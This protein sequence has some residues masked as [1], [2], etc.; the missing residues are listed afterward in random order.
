MI[1]RKRARLAA[2]AALILAA[3]VALALDRVR[4]ESGANQLENE[5]GTTGAGVVIAIIDRGIDW[6]HPDFINDDGT[7]RIKW[8]LDMSNQSN[9]CQVGNPAPVEY[10]EA[11]INAALTGGPTVNS[12]DAVGH[13]TVSAGIA[14]SNGR[15]FANAK[16]RGIA[17]EADLVIVKLTSEGA[18]AH[19][20]EPAETG[21]IACF[22][23]ALDWLETKM[24]AMGQPVV[25][26][27]NIGTQ[28]GPMDG[29]SALSQ[30]I[31]AVFGE[32]NP[33]RIWISPV[34]D[35]GDFDNHAGGNFDNTQDTI[36]NYNLLT[37]GTY[38]ET[39]WYDGAQP[40]E[41]S[42]ELP[43]GTIVGPV[44][45]G[46]SINQSGVFILHYNPGTEF[47]PWA[48]TSGDYA[49]WIR[50]I[51]GPGSGSIRIRGQNAGVG[52][53]DM[54]GS[55]TR[56]FVFT[57]NL[58]PGRMSDIATT[59]SGIV[60]G[61]YVNKNSYTDINSVFRNVSGQGSQDEKWHG[62][63]GGPTRDNRSPGVDILSPGHNLIGSY[64]PTSYWGSLPHLLI[65]DGGGYY[66]IQGAAS[67][68]A[69]IVLGAVALLLEIDPT[70]TAREAR[71]IL[72]STAKSDSFTG[73]TPNTDWG[74]G[75]LD[76][77]AAGMIVLAQSQLSAIVA[78]QDISG[79]G[80]P[81]VGVS[82]PGSTHVHI[83]DG[84]T[85]AL[86]TDINFGD[87]DAL[88]MAVVPDLNASGNPEIAM[89]NEQA[90]GQVRVQIRDTLTGAITKNLYYGLAYEPVAM[91]VIDDY[92]GNG[93]PEIA[94]LGSAAGTDAVRVQVQDTSTGFPRQRVPRHT[95]YCA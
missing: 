52:R 44:A 33:G 60:V 95:E 85:D 68:A 76:I 62:S 42:V 46:G 2:L 86:I 27:A 17:P 8:L 29:T 4:N 93:L 72:R 13:G 35:E 90:S 23:E 55:F 89:L 51:A 58:V 47:Y 21:F 50:I 16:Y 59:R 45:P 11:D 20:G 53:F 94:V 78:M 49:V 61:A 31:D 65:D 12:R 39:M 83:R 48:S 91:D 80:M 19:D 54:Y 18:P 87:D 69:P 5:L 9:W 81:E 26:L 38:I 40:A 41:I 92:S 14:A 10:S 67:G 32:D 63:S 82:M 1:F 37:S 7:T 43:N 30:K 57:S 64:G 88:Q 84:S 73:T 22:D 77:Y 36:T 24:N 74:Y 79:N 6:S 3:P 28:F 66:G 71:D 70:L 25:A 75:K 15:A 56:N 34:G